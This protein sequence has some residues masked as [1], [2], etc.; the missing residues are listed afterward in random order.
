LDEVDGKETFADTALAVEDEVESFNHIV[1]PGGSSSTLAM[2]G[3]R[4]FTGALSLAQAT[5]R[6]L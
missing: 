3:P 6:R 5:H 2:C 1:S 4:L